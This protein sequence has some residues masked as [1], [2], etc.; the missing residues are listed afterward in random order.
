MARLHG[1]SNQQYDALLRAYR[2]RPAAHSEAGKAA[3]IARQTAARYWERGGPE[4]WQ[5]PIREVIDREHEL[6]RSDLERERATAEVE[7]ARELG[8]LDAVR[9]RTHAMRQEIGEAKIS[10]LCRENAAVA[11]ELLGDLLEGV[12][13][14]RTELASA[15]ESGEIRKLVRTRPSEAIALLRQCTKAVHEGAQAAEVAVKLERLIVGK[16][17]EHVGLQIESEAEAR[18]IIER[19]AKAARRHRAADDEAD[20]AVH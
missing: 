18:L 19:A 13:S 17:T 7:H 6:L 8:Q 15:F 1:I 9:A 3:G 14:L 5:K 12:A 11:L 2:G 16:P 10:Q 4:A 20:P